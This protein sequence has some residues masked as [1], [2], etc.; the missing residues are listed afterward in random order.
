MG[1]AEDGQGRLLLRLGAEGGSLSV[2]GPEPGN[3]QAPFSVYLDEGDYG[4]ED[5]E[6]FSGKVHEATSLLAAL[7]FM[8]RYRWHRLFALHVAPDV[9]QVVLTEVHKSQDQDVVNRWTRRLR[10]LRQQG[11]D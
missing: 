4:E 10:T 3:N 9:E 5:L 6:A 7:A 11:A 1:T 8:E 2:Y